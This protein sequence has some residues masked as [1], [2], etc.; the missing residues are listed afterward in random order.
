MSVPTQPRQALCDA[1]VNPLSAIRSF[2]K[3][4]ELIFQLSMREITMKYIGTTLGGLWSF[5]TPLLMLSIYT[6]VFSVVLKSKW[7]DPLHHVE[8]TT[9]FAMILY[10]GLI[11]FSMLTETASRAT[12]VILGVPNYVK[13]VVFPLEILPIV[14]VAGILF[15][16]LINL[17]LLAIGIYWFL[18]FASHTIFLL[19][20]VYLPLI[21]ICIGLA[22][23]ISS[24]CVFAKDVRQ[25]VEIL[26]QLLLFVSP[27]IYPVTAVPESLRPLILMNPLTPI[28]DGFRRTLLWQEPLDWFSW[29]IWTAI[30]L[31]VAWLGYIW[32]MKTKN[33][34]ANIL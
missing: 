17:F 2:W 5:L 27:V 18:G 19:P 14:T 21:F 15:H 24:L 8:G 20:L 34:F 7:N 4:R 11:P 12:A 33:E 6:Y 22:W 16:S 28:L 23:F 3:Y 26:V 32:F 13:K 30:S 1:S 31:M 9:H 10:A 29:S 25:G